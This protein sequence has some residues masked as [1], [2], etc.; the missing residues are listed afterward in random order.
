MFKVS[1]T[2]RRTT[3]FVTLAAALLLSEGT[4]GE[5]GVEFNRD[6]RPILSDACF[7]CHGNDPRS[8]QA[9]LRLDDPQSAF[10]ELPSGSRAIVPGRSEASELIARIMSADADVRMPP[11]D[12]GKHLSESQ[13]KLLKR[14]IDEGAKFQKHW[15]FEPIGRPPL[16]HVRNVDW[17]RNPLD[18]FILARQE[19]EGLG[20]SPEASRATLIRRVTL[21]LTGLPP[22]PAELDAFVADQSSDAYEKLVDR[23]LAS[24]R[25]GEHKAHY[26]L[27]A[28]RYSDTHGMHF[29]NY[30]EIWP[31]RDWVINAFN[32]N[33]PY[34]QFIIE[35]LAGDLLPHPTLDQ[36]IASGFNRCIVT[37]NE[38]GSIY[39]EVYVRNVVDLTNTVG[40][41]F[42]GLTVGCAQCHDHKYDPLTQKEYYQ[43]FAFL[44]S[45]DG[46]AMD[47]NVKNH[48]PFVHVPTKRQQASIDELT[49]QLSA[50]QHRVAD[51]KKLHEAEFQAWLASNESVEMEDVAPLDDASGLVAYYPLDEQ[52]G[53]SVVNAV[54]N[55]LSGTVRGSADWSSGRIRNCFRFDRDRY[56]D[57]GKAGDFT[58]KSPFS[59]G[60]WICT[61]GNVSGSAIARMDEKD[62]DRGY[63]LYIAERRVATHL[64]GSWPQYAINVVTTNEVLEPDTWH[65]VFVTYDGSAQ[66]KGV[67]IYVDGSE[68]PTYAEV[69][70]LNAKGRPA[71][72]TP[73]PLR[74]G[75]RSQ[76]GEPFLGGEIDDVRLFDEELAF[77]EVAAI[78]R[79]PAVDLALRI[80][81]RD[82]SPTDLQVLREAYFEE[83]DPTVVNLLKEQQ[84]MKNQIREIIHQSPT[85]LV[86]RE[87]KT[88]RLAYVLTRGQYDQPA[89]KVSRQTPFVLPPMDKSLPPNRLGL[90]E[91]LTSPTHP[92]T[93]RVA[94][95][96]IW[97]QFFGTGLVKTSEN[98][99]VQG[100]PPSHPELLDWLASEFMKTGWNMKQ[101]DRLIVTS[102][103]Y[104]QSSA[105]PADAFRR[106]PENRL[107]A[108]GPR[109]RLDAEVLRDQALAVSGL[110]VNRLG[111]PSVKPPQPAGLWEAVGYPGSNTV[112]FKPDKGDKVLRRSV[113]IFWK[114]TSPPPYLAIC[115]A[116]SREE[117]RVRRER[118]N[119]PLA[120]LMFMNEQQY[121]QAAGKLAERA[122]T[123]V[124]ATPQKRAAFLFKQAAL[125]DIDDVKLSIL[126][127]AYQDFRTTYR[128]NPAAAEKLRVSCSLEPAGD[129]DPVELAAWT[130]VAN[131][132]LNLDEVI[133]KG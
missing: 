8:R 114:R 2:V 130:M 39:E 13:I 132:V 95:N 62:N 32:S 117:S 80:A 120:A 72:T 4:R 37:T 52:A 26:W 82:R 89:E 56:I 65:H 123:E 53:T 109:Y 88:A 76:G 122:L 27:D 106:D 50:L 33:M 48:A 119:T 6:I 36:Q 127:S 99:G 25:Y 9:E 42:M 47:G 30:R 86:F 121:L 10:S 59:Y 66:A 129:L 20:P 28:I 97:Q 103:T 55:E 16:P 85:S 98:F 105:A 83:I 110:L 118:T 58:G 78:A 116:P 35:Q 104:R 90:A 61:P 31:Y 92:L 128:A 46:H 75:R 111:G 49:T 54:S 51:R 45:M 22:T 29:D 91:W 7:H 102:A 115:D 133:N 77:Y 14:W 64:I 70:S 41:V 71:I 15:S 81:P 79:R 101:L 38:G 108:R 23:L 43:L 17:P 40:T 57:L 18:Y 113:Y 5:N 44:N 93:S 34:N 12:S 87:L 112:N 74:L 21:D 3:V 125:R 73:E 84:A 131:I 96:S 126:L 60:A 124:H 107:L 100:E 24:P 63:D 11:A 94:V 69:D 67:R 68:Q 1:T 19:S